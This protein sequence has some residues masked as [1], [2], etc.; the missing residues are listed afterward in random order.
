MKLHRSLAAFA[1]AAGLVCASGAAAAVMA[2][3]AA[4]APA[5]AG[6]S[7]HASAGNAVIPLRANEVSALK[8]CPKQS[9]HVRTYYNGCTNWTSY[10]CDAGR[11]FN[12]SPP[13]YVSNDCIQTV[14]LWT[15]SGE[16]G[17]AICIPG[18]HASNLLSTKYHSFDITGNGAC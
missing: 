5:A 9:G 16:S 10:V 2:P 15:G 18:Y 6:A 14:Q 11:H 7:S 17:H 4:A 12:I 3:A 1:M 8:T 13:D